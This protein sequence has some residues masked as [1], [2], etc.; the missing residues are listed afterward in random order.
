MEFTGERFV[1]GLK[2]GE[3]IEAEHYLRYHAVGEAVRGKIVLD[4][5][6]GEGYGSA[7]L[8]RTAARV[9]GVE[10][11]AEAVAHARGRYRLG[12]LEYLEGSISALPVPDRSVEVLVSFETIEHVDGPAQARFLEEIGRVL[13]PSGVL[14]I[15]TPERRVYSEIPGYRNEYHVQEFSREEFQAFL[16]QRFG[17][18]TLFDQQCETAY[19]IRREDS[20]ALR[21]VAGGPARPPQGK[22][23]LAVC[24][25]AAAPPEVDLAAGL[26]TGAD[27]VLSLRTEVMDLRARVPWSTGP[28]APAAAASPGIIARCLRSLRSRFPHR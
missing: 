7:L 13:V 17:Q 2:L 3:E 20:A 21:V 19:T 12:N 8:A 26:F 18:V 10:L 22:Y 27:E 1:P 15:S 9:T 14:I 28:P 23:L 11:S 25:N 16:R 5:A 24:S 6:S 4:A